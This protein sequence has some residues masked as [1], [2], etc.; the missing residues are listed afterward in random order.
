MIIFFFAMIRDDAK[1]SYYALCFSCQTNQFYKCHGIALILTLRTHF[2]FIII[3][4]S[5]EFKNQK[6]NSN[7][8]RRHT[9]YKKTKKKKIRIWHVY[10]FNITMILTMKYADFI[11][12][13]WQTDYTQYMHMKHEYT[14]P[15]LSHMQHRR[16]IKIY[17]VS[18]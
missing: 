16:S 10:L 2:F 1:L 15:K 14:A 9:G 18:V 7:S 13:Q 3:I 5:K 11:I 17:Y 12:I 4:N 8:T 6:A